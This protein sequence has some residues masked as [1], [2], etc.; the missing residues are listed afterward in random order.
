M[1]RVAPVTVR[2]TA[3]RPATWRRG[4]AWRPPPGGLVRAGDGPPAGSGGSRRSKVEAG[5]RHLPRGRHPG[6]Q[7]TGWIHDPRLPRRLV[8]RFE[9][10]LRR[11]RP[12]P[13][14]IGCRRLS[15]SRSTSW[16][17]TA[18]SPDRTVMI[19]FKRRAAR[20]SESNGPPA[21]SNTSIA[22]TSATTS[23]VSIRKAR[24]PGDL[25]RTRTI[26]MGRPRSGR[27][28]DARRPK[29]PV[30]AIDS[31][32]TTSTRAANSPTGPAELVGTTRTWAPGRVGGDSGPR[33]AIGGRLRPGG[34]RARCRS[35]PR[36]G[37]IRARSR[38][39]RRGN[40]ARDAGTGRVA[41]PRSAPATGSG[42]TART[43]VGELDEGS[44]A[45][46]SEA[47]THDDATALL[48]RS[49][50]EVEAG[51]RHGTRFGP[52]PRR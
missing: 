32:S 20:S 39:R 12:P 25:A 24:A 10:R 3:A 1:P 27:A 15:E 47:S 17:T 40:A 4:R 2:P 21:A 6:Q 38:R 37:R 18:P 41:S 34:R 43:V 19:G 13:A 7:R 33:G 29:G 51:G 44:R 49:A 45:P 26:A 50:R 52:S 11:R 36:P 23:V 48:I 8:G 46:R 14:G 9:H 28:P 22:V 5:R 31:S 30:T 16:P 35:P 42:F